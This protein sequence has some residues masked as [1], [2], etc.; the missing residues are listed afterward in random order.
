MVDKH[1]KYSLVYAGVFSRSQHHDA[2]FIR[3]DLIKNKKVPIFEDFRDTQYFIHRPCQNKREEILL[4]YE[5]F[6]K[7][8]NIIEATNQAKKIAKKYLVEK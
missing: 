3:N 5:H 2:F 4:D 1:N 7:H 8:N 6:L